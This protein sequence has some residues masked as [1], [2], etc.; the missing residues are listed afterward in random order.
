MDEQ[1]CYLVNR[2]S[3]NGRVDESVGKKIV[4]R[5][6]SSGDTGKWGAWGAER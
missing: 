3:P 5:V 1:S 2:Q 4:A 6:V